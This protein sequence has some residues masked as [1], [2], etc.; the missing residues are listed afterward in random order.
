MATSYLLKTEPSEYSFSD[1]QK[2]KSTIWEGVRNP[3]AVKHLREM[4]RGSRLIIYETG[5][6]KCAVGTAT[7]VSVDARDPKN[8]LVEIQA[9]KLLGRTVTLEEIK[10]NK[11]FRD[12]PLV[13]M[14]RLSVVPLTNA[15]YESLAG[16]S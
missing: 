13:K 1:L 15:Q 14:G 6:K 8:P 9:G 16:R 2:D 5:N 11:L 10:T 3:A 4:E 12:S 7:V